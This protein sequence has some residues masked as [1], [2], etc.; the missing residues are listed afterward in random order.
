M[1]VWQFKLFAVVTFAILIITLVQAAKHHHVISMLGFFYGFGYQLSLAAFVLQILSGGYAIV[2]SAY[3]A[4]ITSG[5]LH[6]HI[7]FFQSRF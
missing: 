4:Y 5:K 2:I 1:S 7:I 6:F 3:I